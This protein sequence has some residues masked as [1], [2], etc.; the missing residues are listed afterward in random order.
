MSLVDAPAVGIVTVV[1]LG[2]LAY[3]FEAARIPAA[4]YAEIGTSKWLCMVGMV[5]GLGVGLAFY[6]VSVRPRLRELHEPDRRSWSVAPKPPTSR[7]SSPPRS[8]VLLVCCGALFVCAG[9]IMSE[10]IVAGLIVGIVALVAA[11]LTLLKPSGSGTS[12][13]PQEPRGDG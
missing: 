9:L 6:V 5:A 7:A 11:T 3:L 4:T 8:I 10:R 2:Y 13:G 12:L 1:V